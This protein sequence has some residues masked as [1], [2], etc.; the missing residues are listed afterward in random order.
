MTFESSDKQIQKHLKLKIVYW[1]LASLSRESY[2][3][4]ELVMYSQQA[5]AFLPLV[6]HPMKYD[7]MGAPVLRLKNESRRY[8]HEKPI[9]ASDFISRIQKKI[10]QSHLVPRV[11]LE[12][13]RA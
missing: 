13:S 6:L 7:L 3:Y 11:G 1:T 9:E 8:G 12:P 5:V 10:Y 4:L 2:W